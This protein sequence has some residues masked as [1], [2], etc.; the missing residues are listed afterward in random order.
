MHICN[1]SISILV[2]ARNLQSSVAPI[3]LSDLLS[4]NDEH[5]TFF[6]SCHSDHHGEQKRGNLQ[7]LRSDVQPLEEQICES[8]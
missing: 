6:L 5:C 2:Q 1:I 7:Q 3:V 8:T 4:H